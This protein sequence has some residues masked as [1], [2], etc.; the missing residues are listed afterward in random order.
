MGVLLLDEQEGVFSGSHGDLIYF[1]CL[2]L[3]KV[4]VS[5]HIK[6]QRGPGSMSLLRQ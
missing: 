1:S 5:E 4:L 3:G 2:A 6:R